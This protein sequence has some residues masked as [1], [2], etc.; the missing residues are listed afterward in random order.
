MGMFDLYKPAPAIGCPACGAPLRKW[1]GKD[2]PCALFVWAQGGVA[3]VDQP[4]DEDL[5][6]PAEERATFR[7]PD[8]FRI[9]ASCPCGPRVEAEGRCEGGTWT[10]TSAPRVA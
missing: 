1:Q 5:R 9:S 3:P 2:G 4:I 6:F 8:T 7:L 10:H